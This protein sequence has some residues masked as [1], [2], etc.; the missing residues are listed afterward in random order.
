MTGFVVQGHIWAKIERKKKSRI[1]QW[2]PSQIYTHLSE[3]HGQD[4]Q[5]DPV[6]DTGELECIINCGHNSKT[7]CFYVKNLIIIQSN[8]I[9]YRFSKYT[10]QRDLKE[11][12]TFV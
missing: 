5:A 8:V 9:G 1:L 10:Q 6:D 12:N 2:D 4:D 7:F 3:E 11:I